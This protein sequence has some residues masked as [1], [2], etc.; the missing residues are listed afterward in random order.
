[1]R[2]FVSILCLALFSSL[3]LKAQAHFLLPMPQKVCW[4]NDTVKGNP[5]IVELVDA[6]PEVEIKS[7]EAYRLT[8]S[9]K[10]IFIKAISHCGVFRAHQTLRQLAISCNEETFYPTCQITDWPAFRMRGLMQ[11]VGRSYISMAELKKEID[12]LSR[13]KINVFHWHLTENQA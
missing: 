3:L 10:G 13:F 8:I 2:I 6:L 11:D 7:D 4:G 12:L 1:M 5:I 9:G